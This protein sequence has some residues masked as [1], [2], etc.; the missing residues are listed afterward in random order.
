LRER[1]GLEN[2][3]EREGMERESAEELEREK[4]RTIALRLK[5]DREKEIFIAEAQESK[6]KLRE[7][8]YAEMDRERERLGIDNFL[9]VREEARVLY[10]YEDEEE[11]E[12]VEEER[13][14]AFEGIDAWL[15]RIKEK[16]ESEP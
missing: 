11:M 2:R 4:G 13:E 7:R 1:E 6:R 14:K 9:K 15:E 16:K 10:K 12:G 5:K 8:M 3:R